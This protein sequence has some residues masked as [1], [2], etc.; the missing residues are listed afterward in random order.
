SPN[1]SRTLS[2]LALLAVVLAIPLTVYIAQKQQE[3]RQRAQTTGSC[4]N[5]HPNDTVPPSVDGRGNHID[6][7]KY[8]WRA[9]NCG[10]DCLKTLDRN[11]PELYNIKCDKNTLDPSV[12][13]DTSNWCY[14]FD[15]GNRCLQLR[16]AAQPD[17]TCNANT[18]CD[19]R[20]VNKSDT[21]NDLACRK[22]GNND[23]VGVY[24][25]GGYQW[26]TLE[27]GKNLCSSEEHRGRT[28]RCGGQI[29]YCD[30][31]PAK[32]GNWVT[33]PPS[34]PPA[35]AQVN[36]CGKSCTVA[37][38]SGITNPTQCT[39]NTAFY[40]QTEGY[41]SGQCG[42]SCNTCPANT[43]PSDDKC[44]CVPMPTLAPA[45]SAVELCNK[46]CRSFSNAPGVVKND[47]DCSDE[48]K[49]IDTSNY[50]SQ[51]KICEFFCVPVPEGNIRGANGC[52]YRSPPAERPPPGDSGDGG[53]NG[54]G[55]GGA[56]AAP[57]PAQP[58]APGGTLTKL[59][60]DLILPE[61]RK[62]KRIVAQ[63]FPV[64]PT[65]AP[66]VTPTITPTPPAQIGQD[67]QGTA[68]RGPGGNHAGTVDVV[69][70]ITTGTYNIKVK[71][72]KY[73]RKLIKDVQITQD[74]TN[75]IS[76]ITLVL[77]DINADN[78]LSI[79]DYNILVD[80]FGD[81]AN[82]QTCGNNN[83][84]FADLDDNGRIDGVDYNLFLR[85]LSSGPREGD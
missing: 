65:V 28:A 24:T 1:Y 2:I 53:G 33:S 69:N 82:S 78:K 85:S 50:N 83:K 45:P 71:A 46:E 54:G 11:N 81:K 41:S 5:L 66:T 68:T 70:A 80:C 51:T 19:A 60:F 59:L 42:T 48:N 32:P 74:A 17:E 9:L 57:P 34:T 67:S 77:G 73:L 14:G 31:I 72:D 4:R 12:T 75:R 38:N 3:I 29:Y 20:A 39:G 13:A 47:Y 84:D 26:V 15:G 63:I 37:N 8:Y 61:A 25:G 79:L 43:K 27:K 36:A 44:S 10:Q 76:Q 58:A 22:I 21:A 49:Y 16:S 6:A 55:G 64:T 40:V 62:D 35:D 23:T 7:D 18:S 52:G 30:P 56:P